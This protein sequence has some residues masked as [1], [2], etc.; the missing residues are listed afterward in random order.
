MLEDKDV[1]DVSSEELITGDIMPPLLVEN[2]CKPKNPYFD[3]SVF[4]TSALDELDPISHS[5][6]QQS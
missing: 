6:N 1:F 3:W 5:E 2:T 4:V